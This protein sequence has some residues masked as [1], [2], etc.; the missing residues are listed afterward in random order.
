MDDALANETDL[1]VHSPEFFSAICE[2]YTTGN[3]PGVNANVLERVPSLTNWLT[4]ELQ[5]S[6]VQREYSYEWFSYLGRLPIPS[7]AQCFVPIKAD[8]PWRKAVIRD[9]GSAL[10]TMTQEQKYHLEP[11]VEQ[12]AYSPKGLPHNAAYSNPCYFSLDSASPS[13]MVYRRHKAATYEYSSFTLAQRK[14][15]SEAGSLNEFHRLLQP[16]KLLKQ[17]NEPP[18]IFQLS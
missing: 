1:T 8:T 15:I 10:W 5:Y 18:L 7:K 2:L 6:E 4:H 13:E 16:G 11:H 14:E 3:F 9:V 17:E 12:Q